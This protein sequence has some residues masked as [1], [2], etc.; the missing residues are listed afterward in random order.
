MSKK[1]AN[2][3]GFEDVMKAEIKREH[4][5]AMLADTQAEIEAHKR[6]ARSLESFLATIKGM[7]SE[8]RLEIR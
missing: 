6:E 4:I 3:R 1:K 5:L 2:K 7:C 8:E